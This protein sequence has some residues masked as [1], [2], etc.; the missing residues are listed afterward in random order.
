MHSLVNFLPLFVCLGRASFS[1]VVECFILI[2]GKG[3]KVLWKVSQNG[4]PIG[5]IFVF[6]GRRI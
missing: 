4:Q 1:V 6:G 3:A 5:S 2:A